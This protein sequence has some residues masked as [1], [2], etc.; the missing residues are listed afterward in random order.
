V[1]QHVKVELF[2]KNEGVVVA[3]VETS[4]GLTARDVIDGLTARDAKR[5]PPAAVVKDGVQLTCGHCQSMLW[6]RAADG[7]LF[8]ANPGTVAAEQ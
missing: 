7:E 5:C 6:F 1:P 2:C 4:G 8:P 3:E